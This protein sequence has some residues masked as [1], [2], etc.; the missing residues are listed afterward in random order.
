MNKR[1]GIFWGVIAAIMIF[2]CGMVFLNILMP[3]VTI[4]RNSD[5][6]DCANAA[7]ISD[8]N[9]VACLIVGLTIPY[10]II[11]LLSLV[12]GLTIGYLK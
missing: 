6:L 8:G 1:G 7:G 12:G 10:Y 9:K 5:N 3:D 4:A 2:M 11:I